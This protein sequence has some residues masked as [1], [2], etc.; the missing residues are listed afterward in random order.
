MHGGNAHATKHGKN[1][2]PSPTQAL[3][4]EQKHSPFHRKERQRHHERSSLRWRQPHESTPQK[5]QLWSLRLKYPHGPARTYLRPNMLKYKIGKEVRLHNT[6]AERL[7]KEAYYQP[8]G[9]KTVDWDSSPR[10]DSRHRLKQRLFPLHGLQTRIHERKRG[11]LP[12]SRSALP[13][14]RPAGHTFYAPIHL[15]LCASSYAHRRPLL[16]R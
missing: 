11:L 1:T 16:L 5:R 2:F 4:N 10:S 9:T 14:L 6:L 8:T 12:L 3:M 7:P 15:S 13:P